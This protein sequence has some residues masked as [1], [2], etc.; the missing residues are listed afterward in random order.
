[1]KKIFGA[2]AIF[3]FASAAA[4][5]QE[6]TN[7]DQ[8]VKDGQYLEAFKIQGEYLWPEKNRAFQV[9]ARGDKTFDVVGYQDGLPG[10]GWDRS[11][12]RFFGKGEL[13]D[14]KLVVTGERMD[15]PRKGDERNI[16]FNDE[17]KATKLVAFKEGDKI[18]L[19]F[20]GQSELQRVERKSET[21]GMKAPEGAIVLFDGSNTDAFASDVHLSDAQENAIWS[22]TLLKPFEKDRP[23]T[24]HLEFML[25][26]M[27]NAQGQ[28]RSNSGVYLQEEYECQVLD[29]FGLEGENNECAGFYQ[30]LK[31]IVN[32][33][34]PP[35]TW[36]TY[37][38]DVTPAKFNEKGEKVA[39]AVITVKH[40]GILVHDKAVLEHETPGGKTEKTEA[41]EARGVFL[42]G[43]GNKVQYRNIWIKYND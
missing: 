41:G 29:S 7:V 33:C 3:A 10:A 15:I 39:N 8:I 26:F 14:G 32:A 30:Q 37:D 2:L 43:H 19:D 12:A 36:Q 9:I 42:Q 6:F 35:L 20:K 11:K 31:P 18:I 22:E 4:L 28:A 16:V 25:S 17:Q 23:F 34:L 24:L 38:F 27:P 1:M 40:N 5:G 21:L 13:Q